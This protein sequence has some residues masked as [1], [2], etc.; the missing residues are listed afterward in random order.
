MNRAELADFLRVRRGK[1]QPD[2]VGL[3]TGTRR[4]TPGLRRQEV[5]QLAG[6]SV[7]Y[8]IRLE[9]ARGPRPSRQVL[10]ALARALLLNLD[11]R[12]HL[13]HLVGETLEP[14]AA[15]RRDVP[16]GITHLLAALTE[17]PAYLVDAG[18]TVLAANDLARAFMSRLPR[19]ECAED[20]VVRVMFTGPDAAARLADPDQ[21]RFARSCV[22]DLRAAAA[23]YPDDDR[24]RGLVAELL[25]ASPE[26]GEIW[27]EHEV[28]VRRNMTKHVDHPLVGPIDVECQV[29]SVPERDQRLIL[30]VAEPGSA[31]QRA[32][33]RLREL[34]VAP[35]R[36]GG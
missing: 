17:I 29:L 24:L 10:G 2:H 14:A 22:A 31:S 11:Q 16:E 21:L 5:A 20:N 36:I 30:Y 34:A 6:M 32:I 19:S 3:P 33:R 18:Y 15:V 8:Y 28:E 26:F 25:R 27:A 9:Q 1:L 13:F 7:D 35:P 23:R 4:R 12:A